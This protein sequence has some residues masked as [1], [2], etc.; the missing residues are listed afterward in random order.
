MVR[1]LAIFQDW[2]KDFESQY[3]LIGGTAASITMAEAGLPF[4][5]T[6]DLDIVLHVE[7]LTPAFGQKFW[8]FVQAGGYQ[9][10]EGDPKQKPCLYRFQKP[11]DEEYPYMLE[12][13]SRVPD[14]LNF[15][16]PGHLTPIPMDEQISSLSAI[17][18]NDE[19]YQFVLAG[20]KNKHGIPSWVGED[21]LIPLKAVAWLEMTGRVRQGEMIDSKKINKHQADI[22]ELSALLQPGQIVELP[23]KLKDDLQAFSKA[24]VALNRP[25]QLQAMKRIA[26]AYGFDL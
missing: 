7:V 20:R 1:G 8:E 26:V 9:K 24:V 10:K 15:V 5:G 3:V 23:E 14:G 4:R 18:L 17:L 6:K 13:F 11:L 16:P 22:V 12:L 19:Y 21:R 25:E 2:F